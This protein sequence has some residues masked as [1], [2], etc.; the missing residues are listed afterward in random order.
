[1]IYRNLLT[2]FG[3]ALALNAAASDTPYTGL[4]DRPIKALSA[5]QVEGLEA[6]RGMGFALAAELNGYPGPMHVL[7]LA[8]ELELN[9][10]QRARTQAL[11]EEMRAITSQYGRELVEAERALDQAFAEQRITEDSLAGM[12]HRI[13]ELQRDIR[14]EHLATH[15][16]QTEL[17]TAEQVAAYNRLRGYSG[18]GGGHPHHHPQ[19]HH[20]GHHQQGHR[21]RQ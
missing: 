11:F 6:G 2:A 17:L 10:G 3:L 12:L 4:Q 8:D 13:A 16:R 5:E 1:M 18:D 7:E 9:P 15:L 21:H 19:G 14:K 20:H